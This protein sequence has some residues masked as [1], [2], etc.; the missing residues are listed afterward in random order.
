MTVF[1]RILGLAAIATAACLAQPL[2]QRVLI[3]HNTVVPD[4]LEVANYYAAQRGIPSSNICAITST[5]GRDVLAYAAVARD[6]IRACLNDVG[7]SNILYIVMMYGTPWQVWPGNGQMYMLDSYLA[8]IWDR[9]TSQNFYPAP[10]GTHAYYA[11]TQARGNW[12]PPFV[13]FA[14]FRSQPKSYP[15]YSVWRLD[16]PSKDLAKALVDRAIAA[17]ALAARTGQGCFDTRSGDTTTLADQSYYTADWDIYRASQFTALSGFATTND[18]LF[19]EFGTAPS[20]LSCPNALLYAGWYSFNN[21]NDAF[22][23]NPGAIGWHMDSASAL[24]PRGGTNW[25]ANAIQRGI[26]ITAGSAEEPY[27]QG[28]PRAGGVIRNL[29]EG[30]NAGDAMTRNTRWLK[31]RVMY[32]GDPL[33]RPFPG[34][35]APFNAPV[36]ENSLRITIRQL[37]G[38][39][40]S[41]GTVQLAA[42]APS[43]GTAVSLV[44]LNTSLATVPASVTVPAGGR[45][46]NFAISTLPVAFRQEV[47][48]AATA[49]GVS[50]RNDMALY[51]LLAGLGLAQSTIQ[52]GQ[53]VAAGVVL[54]DRAPAGVVV[55]ALNSD[56]PAVVTVPATVTIPTG[57]TTGS[58][59][60]TTSAVASNTPVTVRAS[61]AGT[62]VSAMLTV[63]P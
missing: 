58:F 27:L 30:A 53:A 5:D 61:F 6:P 63:T 18:E 7:A 33:Y 12:Y 52:G 40:G 59:N 11:D 3:V 45:S 39:R 48:I 56:N 32:F 31:W 21:Y 34:G 55:I 23:W 43:G 19:S 36:L 35:V 42:A 57:G 60:V 62:Q 17:E 15:M 20:P 46:A 38:G 47:W 24:N 25:V 22:T 44:S 49:P 14:S 8:D 41:V 9:Y 4:S 2:N 54:N 10:T 26:T 51:P 50:L 37:V 29:L 13:S 28:L 1:K 16:A